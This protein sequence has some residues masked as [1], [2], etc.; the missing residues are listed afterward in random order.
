MAWKSILCAYSGDAARGSGLRHAV[1]VAKHHDAHLTGVLLHGSSLMQERLQPRL[2][3]DLIDQLQG[4]ERKHIADIGDRFRAAAAAGGLE[5]KAEFVEITPAEDGSLAE[6]AHAYD[7]VVMGNHSVEA[8]DA[9]LSPYPDLVALRSGRPVMV[10]PDDYAGEGLA[11]RAI[12]AWDGSRAATRALSD[13][14]GVLADKKGVKLV[15]VGKTPRGTDRL[16]MNLGRHGVTATFEVASK[17]GSIAETLLKA[18]ADFDA[19]LLVLGAF[20]HS[21]FS[22]D[23]FGGV[24]T[25]VIAKAKIPVLMAH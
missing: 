6:F 7:L 9:H 15:G 4:A 18:A 21:K 19:R 12:V 3:Q 23:L 2:P 20:E 14:I 25:Q 1:R 17:R 5:G 16:L 11:E 22:H 8:H 10:V 13:T 24:T